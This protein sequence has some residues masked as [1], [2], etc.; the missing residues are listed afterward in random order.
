MGPRTIPLLTP[1]AVYSSNIDIDEFDFKVQ[2]S[3]VMIDGVTLL[4]GATGVTVSGKVVSLEASGATLDI[5]TE[6]FP[7]PTPTRS[8]ANNGSMNVQA[9]TDGQGKGLRVVYTFGL[10]CLRESYAVDMTV[11]FV[12]IRDDC[13]SPKASRVK[14]TALERKGPWR[15]MKTLLL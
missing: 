12:L 4:P 7:L 15:R 11:V 2:S 13:Y 5:G 10:R 6:H 14:G 9:F 1:Q 8:A 3:F